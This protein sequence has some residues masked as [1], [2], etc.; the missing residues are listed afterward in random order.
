MKL[1]TRWIINMQ[2]KKDILPVNFG[3]DAILEARS[4]HDVPSH[5]RIG[6]HFVRSC[7]RTC[8]LHFKDL[9]L[10]TCNLLQ[11]NF[12]NSCVTRRA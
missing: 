3:T 4:L 11:K 6:G 5:E 1:E 7:S 9:A 12:E 2:A 10:V 8:D